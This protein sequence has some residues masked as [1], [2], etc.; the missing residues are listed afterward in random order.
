MVCYRL[1]HAG[2]RTTHLDE[3]G[4]QTKN[5]I[6]TLIDQPEA[7]K[8]FGKDIVFEIKALYCT[9]MGLNL[10]NKLAYGLLNDTDYQSIKVIYAWWLGLQLVCHALWN[11]ARTR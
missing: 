4:V 5:R 7:E 11:A 9:A 3:H 2:A 1:K 8:V 10:R 6:S